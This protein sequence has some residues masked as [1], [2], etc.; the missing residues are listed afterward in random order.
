MQTNTHPHV[1]SLASATHTYWLNHAF[2]IKHHHGLSS[3]SVTTTFPLSAGIYGTQI[4]MSI[5]GPVGP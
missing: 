3:S 2:Q 5:G 1:L 4:F